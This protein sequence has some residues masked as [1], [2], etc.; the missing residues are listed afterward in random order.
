ME[1]C[2]I[3][4]ITDRQKTV[5]FSTSI[6]RQCSEKVVL[7]GSAAGRSPASQVGAAASLDC[8]WPAP[9]NTQHFQRQLETLDLMKP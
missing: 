5:M 8:H 3:L 9:T 1:Y 6:F 4:D 2:I 7:A